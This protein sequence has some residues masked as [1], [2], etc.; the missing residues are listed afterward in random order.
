MVMSWGA[1]W[2]DGFGFLSQIVDSRVIRPAG[3]TNLGIKLPEVDKLIDQAL[4][5]ERH[6]QA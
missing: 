1:D 2:P 3:N 5:R 4:G 6:D